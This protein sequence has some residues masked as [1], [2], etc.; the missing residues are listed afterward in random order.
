MI[1]IFHFVQYC[2]LEHDDLISGKYFVTF[3]DD[4]SSD[5]DRILRVLRENNYLPSMI[6]FVTE[7]SLFKIV[8]GQN[9]FYLSTDF[10][11]CSTF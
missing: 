4:I 2:L 7:K 9:F 5:F 11:F 1:I 3:Y 6:F 10:F 8:F